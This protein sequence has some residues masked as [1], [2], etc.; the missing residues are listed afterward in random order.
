MALLAHHAQ[1]AVPEHAAAQERLELLAHV[2]G[3]R[4]VF[5][6]KTRNEI[7]VVRLYPRVQLR[8]FGNMASIGR[9]GRQRGR[10][11]AGIARRCATLQCG[12]RRF[13]GSSPSAAVRPFDTA[14]CRAGL[15]RRR[16]NGYV[17]VL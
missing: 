1:E 13:R 15:S 2:L 12:E 6:R 5:C 9:R 17:F 10:C 7:R 16:K 4:A 14:C 3:Q 11:G 8:A